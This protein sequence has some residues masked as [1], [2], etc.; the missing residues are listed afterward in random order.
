MAFVRKKRVKGRD[1]YQL[2]ESRRV[3]GS[4]RQRVLVHL[5]RYATVDEALEGL[6]GEI[7]RA[8]RYAEV[9]R[10]PSRRQPWRGVSARDL[11]GAGSVERRAAALE[12][13]LNEL[14]RLREGGAA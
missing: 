6:P 14:R 5:G 7:E 10:K 4:P 1:Y 2:V 13:R 9:L 11:E 3:D 8:R 12:D